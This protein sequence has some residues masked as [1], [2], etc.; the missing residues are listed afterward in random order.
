[1]EEPDVRRMLSGLVDLPRRAE[2][3]PVAPWIEALSRVRLGLAD[4]DGVE[5]EVGDVS[6][7]AGVARQ[8]RDS[9]RE[10]DAADFDEQ[11]TS[12]IERLLADPPF[13]RRSQRYARVLLV[14]EFQDLTPAHMLLIRLLS[15]PAGAVFGVGDDDQT[16]YGYAG[17]TPRWL[18]D[19]DRWFPG[20]ADHSL[21]VNYRCPAP[22]V[23]AASHLLTHNSVRVAKTIR[24]YKADGN[25]RL[26]V[27]VGGSR[28]ATTAVARVVDLLGAGALPCRYRRAVTG[29]R[30]PGPDPRRSC[31]I[32]VSPSTGPRRQASCTEAEFGP[33]WPGCRS[34][35]R[36]QQPSRVPRSGRR[37]AG[38]N[39]VRANHSWTS[40]PG[41]DPL[42]ASAI[43]RTGCR[44]RA[45]V[46]KRR[47][48]ATSSAMSSRC[49]GPRAGPAPPL[50]PC[51]R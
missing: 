35:S 39:G 22:V 8:Y 5:E 27:R 36:L 28:P 45:A 6:G 51:S 20:S 10:R 47:R 11:V 26:E 40:W 23:Q 38:R 21:E 29:Q 31:D 18:V 19:F 16:I 17:A 49:A 4:P 46:A 34:R 32:R 2:A 13:R 15:G 44:T 50:P 3:D 7:L 48:Y 9:L 33:R 42:K 12:A 24:A 14:D 43:W 30:V 1:M 37:L 41:A 25:G